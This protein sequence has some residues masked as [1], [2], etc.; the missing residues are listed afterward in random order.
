MGES[1]SCSFVDCSVLNDCNEMFADIKCHTQTQL[2][3]IGYNN[4]KQFCWSLLLER[5]LFFGMSNGR[6]AIIKIASKSAI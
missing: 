1:E 4:I 5:D 6:P 2:H 3:L